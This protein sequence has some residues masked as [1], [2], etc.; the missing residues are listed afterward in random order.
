MVSSMQFSPLFFLFSFLFGVMAAFFA[1]SRGKNP[2]LWFTIGV[3]FGLCG[4][5]A[6]LFPTA[7]RKRVPQRRRREAPRLPERRIEGPRD[8]FWYYLDEEQQQKGPMSFQAIAQAW[9][10]GEIV[11]HTFVWHEQLPEW[12]PLGDLIVSKN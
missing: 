9:K 5:V 7:K 4:V 2:Y 12:K 6:L 11:S 8:C 1:K 10:K 3:L